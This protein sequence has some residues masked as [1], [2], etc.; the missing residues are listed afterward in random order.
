MEWSGMESGKEIIYLCLVELK[1]VEWEWYG[2]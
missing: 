1:K 2:Q